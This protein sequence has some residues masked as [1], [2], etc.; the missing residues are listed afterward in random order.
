MKLPT[1]GPLGALQRGRPIITA[2]FCSELGR[3]MSNEQIDRAN[4]Q[5]L[6][7]SCSEEARALYRKLL[8]KDPT[9]TRRLALTY[10]EVVALAARG[11][12]AQRAEKFREVAVA[13]L[14]DTAEGLLRQAGLRAADIDFLMVCCMAGKTLPR[15]ASHVAGRVGFRPELVTYNL[16]DMGCSVGVTAIDLATRLLR[17][18]DRPRR[19][20]VLALE[21]VS[22]LFQLTEDAGGIV[23]NTLF[24]EGC[25]GVIVSTHREPA[26]Y[27]FG[28]GQRTLLADEQGRQAITLAFVPTGALIQL[29]KEIP[30]VAGQAIEMNLRRLVPRFISPA[31]ALRYLITRKVPRWQRCI[32]RGAVHPGGMV[33]LR[34]LQE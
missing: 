27:H 18:E 33:V 29:S 12:P 3:A 8:H 11:D 5:L 1:I 24:G 31:D 14:L 23:G 16:G 10:A 19:A 17:A 9:R 34:T 26:L 25:A 4:E 32:S 2:L 7:S 22:N 20:M 21:P 15:L 13:L 30:G 6:Y 28:P